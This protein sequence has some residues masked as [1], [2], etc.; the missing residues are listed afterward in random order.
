VIESFCLKQKEPFNHRRKKKNHFGRF[1][2]MQ[3]ALS[4]R[5]PT[6]SAIFLAFW[7]LSPSVTAK[8]YSSRIF[9]RLTPVGQC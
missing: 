3:R 2:A 8:R 5:K 4:V 7:A 9:G 6:L 1:K